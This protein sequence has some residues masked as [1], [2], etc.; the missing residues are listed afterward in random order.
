MP[1]VMLGTWL[2]IHWQSTKQVSKQRFNYGL[3]NYQIS[4]VDSEHL[5]GCWRCSMAGLNLNKLTIPIALGV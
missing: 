5:K 4:E 2:P 1:I 3:K